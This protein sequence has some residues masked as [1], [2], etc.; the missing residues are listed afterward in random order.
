MSR[1]LQIKSYIVDGVVDGCLGAVKGGVAVVDV[2]LGNDGVGGKQ[3]VDG[4]E[5]RDI[6]GEIEG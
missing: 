4:R 1:D 2:A 5:K 3:M 6:D